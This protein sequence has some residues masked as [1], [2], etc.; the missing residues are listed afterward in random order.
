MVSQSFS[1]GPPPRRNEF[2]IDDIPPTQIPEEI[3]TQLFPK[4]SIS[5]PLC[6]RRR[7]VAP[8]I[9]PSK[10]SI[11]DILH[12]HPGTSL[13][14][15]PFLWTDQ[16]TTLLGARFCELPRCDT[17][18]P[19]NV[20]GSPPSRGHVRPSPAI[21]TLSHSLSEMLL[22]V[23]MFPVNAEA[24]TDLMSTLWPA[25]FSGKSYRSPELPMFFGD[26]VY[27]DAARA[28]VM[29]SYPASNSPSI[30]SSVGSVSTGSSTPAGHNPANLPMMCYINRDSL[31][32]MRQNI[33]RVVPGPGQTSNESV[34]RLQQARSKALLPANSDHDAQFMAIFL[35]MA[36]R[37]F[38]KPP[39]PAVQRDTRWWTAE[40]PP[41][42][43]DFHDMKLRILTHETDTADFIL[44]TGHV[45]AKFLE[46]FHDPFKAPL[47]DDGSVP[48][49]KIE[50]TRIPIWPILGLRERLGKALGEDIVGPFDPTIMETW[51]DDEA[52]KEA[53]KNGKRKRGALSEVF[54]GS[55][56]E[57]TDDE[58]GLLSVKRKRLAPALLCRR[59]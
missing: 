15:R 11:Y 37:H 1:S 13:F 35:A 32:H 4:T 10:D 9:R 17:P 23:S 3:S 14:V 58:S 38:Y 29:W 44:Y 7:S 30:H 5:P 2:P 24:V 21:K 8:I 33:F 42:R 57:G 52:E 36:Q 55:F 51:Y 47:D 34:R 59:D 43:P 28:H 6:R 18:L 56:E 31:L 19:N 45:T 50:Y 22:P 41:P 25:A 48:G 26:R 54:N 40:G 53:H 16:H 12:Q 39:G 49:L 46:R 20:P 27:R